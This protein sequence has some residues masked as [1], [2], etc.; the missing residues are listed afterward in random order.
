M[1]Q[2]KQSVRLRK[3]QWIYDPDIGARPAPGRRRRHY[4]VNSSEKICRRRPSGRTGFLPC[5]VTYR[6]IAIAAL[7]TENASHKKGIIPTLRTQA[8]PVRE[9]LHCG[10]SVPPVMKS[11]IVI[12]D[13]VGGAITDLMARKTVAATVEAEVVPRRLNLGSRHSPRMRSSSTVLK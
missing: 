6:E 10:G 12:G 4:V 8:S 5:L 9:P 7:F 3:N 13:S 11:M 1:L 2:L